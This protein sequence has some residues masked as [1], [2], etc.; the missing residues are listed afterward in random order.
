MIEELEMYY[1]T[2]RKD[3]TTQ[4]PVSIDKSLYRH[5]IRGILDGDGCILR[6]ECRCTITGNAPLIDFMVDYIQNTLSIHCSCSFEHHSD[7]TKTLR[8]SGRKQAKVFLDYIY[9]DADLY[10]E[11]KHDIYLEKYCA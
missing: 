3:F 10:I 9:E 11:R 4:F 7:K 2:P 1:I 5:V 8:I 6:T